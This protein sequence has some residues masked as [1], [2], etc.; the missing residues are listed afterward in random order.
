MHPSRRT[1]RVRG[2]PQDFDKNKLVNVLRHH[3]NL[4][5][6]NEHTTDCGNGIRVH[7][8]APDTSGDQVA[9]IRFNN[10]PPQLDT[11]RGE[12][13]LTITIDITPNYPPAK[14]T[15]DEHFNGVT[16]LV[17]PRTSEEHQI[18]LLAVPGLGGHPYGSFVHKVDGNMWLSD[19]LPP[20]MPAARVMLYGY[21]S[22]LQQSTRFIQLDGLA[23]GLHIAITELL[24]SEKAK[25]LILIGHSLGG[26][27][28]K[29]ALIRIAESDSE[30][31]L[32]PKIL[33]MLL[34]GAP[35]DGMNIA[36]L[37]PM[38]SDQPNRFLLESLNFMNSQILSFQKREFSRVLRSAKFELY[39]LYETELSPTATKVDHKPSKIRFWRQPTREQYKMTGPLQCLVSHS[40]ATSCLP[41]EI[42][43]DH[44]VAIDRTHSDLVKFAT[45]D[46]EYNKV[47]AILRQIHS[48]ARRA[49]PQLSPACLDCLQSLGFPQMQSRSKNIDP[50]TKG[51]CE[52]LFQHGTYARW[53]VCDRGLLWIKGKPGS[54][55]STLLRHALDRMEESA[56]SGDGPLI[57]SFF[58][59]DRGDD[60]Q[61]SP[62]GLFRSLLHQILSNVPDALSGLV[63]TFERQ[64][65]DVGKPGE[66]WLWHL[67]DLQDFF[68]SSLPKILEDR[69]IWLFVDALDETGKDN[70]TMVVKKFKELL[71][72]LSPPK[73]GLRII[74]SCRHYPLLDGDCEFEI[75]VELENEA[76][77]ST[78]VQ[79]QLTPSPRLKASTLAKLITES[80]NGVF[81]WAHLVVHQALILH[82]EG[83]GLNKI[84]KTVNH[85]PTSLENLYQELVQSMDERPASL[86]LL[87]WICFAKRPLSL[88]ELRWAMIVD[89]KCSYK[90]FQQC[91]EDDENDCDMEKRL[92]TLSRGLVETVPSVK[93]RVAQFIHQS[94]KDFFVGKGLLALHGNLKPAG[95]ET[96]DADLVTN[97]AHYQLSRTC[98]RYLGMEEIAQ[99]TVSDRDDLASVFPLLRYATTSWVAHTKQSDQHDL[100]DFFGWPSEHLVQRWVHVYGKMA[101]FS[102]DCPPKGISLL[103]IAAQY[104]L[105]GAVEEIMKR[106]VPVE[107]LDMM[108]MDGRSALF[109]AA[110]SGHGAVVKKLLEN[111]ASSNSSDNKGWTPL[112]Y[113]A[114]K[115]HEI[116]VEDLLLNN[117]NVNAQDN[118]GETALHWAVQ[119][120]NEAIISHLLKNAADTEVTD[121]RGGTPLAWAIEIRSE[122]IVRKLLQR[123]SAVN[124]WYKTVSRYSL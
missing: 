113:A 64:C 68:M 57:L 1:W 78:Y 84:R 76:D 116:V 26:L 2:V 72:E 38:V 85:T 60:L 120:E 28:V 110:G 8:L 63:A 80:A 39:C 83:A 81:L 58:F 19:S 45:H 17:A 114:E 43:R 25:P 11:L 124:Y 119:R 3:Q 90:S 107:T 121:K 29:E 100:L 117:A 48:E 65:R 30:L 40:S 98:I 99:S 35:N 118:V 14:L 106:D 16:T 20:T 33:G 103:H 74:F 4:Q 93:F 67:R 50:A 34:F 96:F 79:A 109:Y 24:R 95:T 112:L 94:V 12:A 101:P 104:S 71:E 115:G 37:I 15:I 55:K 9:T 36:S 52:W 102:A 87:Q 10:L 46:S 47:A 27:L 13:Q 108:N 62:L 88:E 69:P 5:C 32:L 21:A 54:G 91:E 56:G 70:A 22:A 61:K 44:S 97:L 23:S 66:K 73:F 123:H 122:T 31:G 6:P 59:H 92:K 77:I 7:T 75:C 89:A 82:E 42:A 49:A 41:P 53:M 111:G 86:K 51:T 105:L 18:D